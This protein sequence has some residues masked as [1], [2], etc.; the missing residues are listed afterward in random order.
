MLIYYS[1]IY[2]A[3]I[4]GSVT[5]HLAQMSD[6]TS[7]GKLAVTYH[8]KGIGNHANLLATMINNTFKPTD[9]DC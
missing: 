5:F 2:V 4:N 3:Q 8:G 1:D 9:N 6:S 7:P